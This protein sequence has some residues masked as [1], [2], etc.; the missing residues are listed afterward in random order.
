M[1][2]RRAERYYEEGNKVAVDCVLK[3]YFDTINHQKLMAYLS[4]YIKDKVL[5][6]LIQRF[7]QTG[8]RILS[9]VTEYLE[10]GLRLTAN[11]D[12]S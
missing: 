2:I 8:E 1:A 11:K 10:K 9:S 7:Q 3:G 12:K 6:N 5:V 4:Y